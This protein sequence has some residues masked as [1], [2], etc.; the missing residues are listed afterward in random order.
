MNGISTLAVQEGLAHCAGKYCHHASFHNHVSTPVRKFLDSIR[1]T[2]DLQH[3][4]RGCGP[5]LN[6]EEDGI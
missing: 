4:C 3:H 2:G 5:R 1:D 6:K